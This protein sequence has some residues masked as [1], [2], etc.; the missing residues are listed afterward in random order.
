VSGYLFF[1]DDTFGW[2]AKDYW[3]MVDIQ[4]RAA[5]YY[6]DTYDEDGDTYDDAGD[7]DESLDDSGDDDSETYDDSDN[8]PIVVGYPPDP[9]AMLRVNA[10]AQQQT[11]AASITRMYPGTIPDE[12]P[13]VQQVAERIAADHGSSINALTRAAARSG[14]LGGASR[15]R[16]MLSEI[17]SQAAAEIGYGSEPPR[18]PRY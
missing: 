16:T 14:D 12:M 11:H 3:R 9:R 7:E 5:A 8:E 6:A 1:S 18:L 10:R 17:Y 4:A 15:A 2:N 13:L